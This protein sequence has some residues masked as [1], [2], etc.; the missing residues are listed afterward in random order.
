MLVDV[1]LVAAGSGTRMGG[2]DKSL[3]QVAGEPLLR[4]S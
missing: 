4:W 1:V 3:I 2:I